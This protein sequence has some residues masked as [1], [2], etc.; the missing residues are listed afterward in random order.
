VNGYDIGDEH[1]P[2]HAGGCD[3]AVGWTRRQFADG[4]VAVGFAQAHDGRMGCEI[5]SVDWMRYRPRGESDVDKLYRANVAVV[6]WPS[7]LRE[8][9][10]DVGIDEAINAAEG[11]LQTYRD[12]LQGEVFYWQV[13]D[14]ATGDVLDSCGGYVGRS[15]DTYALSEAVASAEHA[16][17]CRLKR[18]LSM[19]G[20]ARLAF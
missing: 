18:T 8:C 12:Y 14:D 5:G 3:D 15:E 7:D 10:G 19:F 6:V 2:H 16:A 20:H 13:T 11:E 1:Y 9:C 17:R 4:A